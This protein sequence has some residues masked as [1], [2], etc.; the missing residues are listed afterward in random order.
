M[1]TNMEQISIWDILQEKN[2]KVPEGWERI[3]DTAEVKAIEEPKDCAR[4]Q[5]NPYYPDKVAKGR[6]KSLTNFLK[7]YC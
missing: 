5:D 2:N 3:P 7:M 4:P 6:V 1:V